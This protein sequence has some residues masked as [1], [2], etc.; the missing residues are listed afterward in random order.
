MCEMRDLTYVHVYS[1]R[2]HTMTCV[3]VWF[4][5]THN[6]VCTCVIYTHTRTYRRSHLGWHF[7]MLFQSSTLKAPT[8]LFTETWQER[9]SSFELWAFENVTP[10]G[11]GC[12]P[13]AC[14]HLCEMYVHVWHVSYL[15]NTYMCD[16][17]T[18]MYTHVRTCVRSRD[19]CV[20]KSHM[21]PR[22]QWKQYLL[23]ATKLNLIGLFSAERGKR[24]LEN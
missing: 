22:V 1:Y 7:R 5:H 11:I 10:S 4:T 17:H 2:G 20:Y 14:T 18:R 12:T 3:R 8:S 19:M 9:R 13:H 6:D 24:D 23:D 15:R 21:Y 16:L